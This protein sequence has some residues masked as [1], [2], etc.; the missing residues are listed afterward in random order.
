MK[1]IHGGTKDPNL[2][3]LIP[4]L[5]LLSTVPQLPLHTIPRITDTG[6][7]TL[8]PKTAITYPTPAASITPTVSIHSIISVVCTTTTVPCVTQVAVQIAYSE[9]DSLCHPRERSSGAL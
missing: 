8:G 7:I 6:V 3:G 1:L 5:Q 9:K 4:E 2:T